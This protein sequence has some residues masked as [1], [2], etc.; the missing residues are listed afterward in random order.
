MSATVPTNAEFLT[1]QKSVT[2]LT[3]RV[4]TAEAAIN[5]LSARLAAVETPAPPLPQPVGDP[6]AISTLA[7]VA[8]TDT[9]VTLS[10]PEVSDG[11]GQPASYEVRYSPPGSPWGTM[12][13]VTQGTCAVLAGRTIGATRTCTVLGLTPGTTYQF[14]LVAYRGSLNTTT[15]VFGALSNLVSGS[16]V[17]SSIIPVPSGTWPNE[18]AGMTLVTDEPFNALVENGWQQVQRQTTNGSGLFLNADPTAPFSPGGIL[19]FKYAAGY[20]GGSEPGVAYY[21]V[22]PIQETYFG[23]WWK[24]SNPWQNHSGSNVNKLAFLFPVSGGPI[25]I[26]MYREGSNYFLNTEPEFSGDVRRLPPNVTATPITLGQWHRVEWYVKYAT[27]GSSRDGI[28]RWW[29]DGVLQGD[30]HDLQTPAD[31]GFGEYQ[32]APTWG[33]IGG[34]KSETDY[35]WYDHARISRR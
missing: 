11:T 31:A 24:P 14:Q 23:F 32:I 34:T 19:E 29:L 9:S 16:T 2:N 22:A 21:D 13:P 33:G 27:S 26:M 15:V 35:Y 7:V 1:L 10:F 6:G 28:S 4:T 30:Y 20:T 12:S 18:P 8:T 17:P 3:T 5:D 25:Y